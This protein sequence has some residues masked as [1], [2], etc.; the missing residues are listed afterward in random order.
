MIHVVTSG[1]VQL[2][3]SQSD[4]SFLVLQRARPGS[5][6]AE[7][8]LYSD[9]YHCDAVAADPAET[10]VYVSSSLKKLLTEDAELGRLWAMHLA[11]QLQNARLRSE[12]LSMK[13]VSQRLDAWIAWH[14]L[15]SLEKGTW[16][17]IASQL[18]VSPEA[19][20]RELSK[21][22]APACS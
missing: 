4:G 12:I 11:Q 7:A 2:V 18:G 22:R 19:L 5:I 21:R 1:T 16:N 8:S 17:V 14:G 20:Y 9:A 3:R 13:T 15:E 10:L 6:V